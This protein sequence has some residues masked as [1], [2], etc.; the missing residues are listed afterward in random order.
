[1]SQNPEQPVTSQSAAVRPVGAK[2]P[3]DARQRRAAIVAGAVA[4]G[5]FGI[6]WG[7]LSA[8][9][10]LGF[11]VIALGAVLLM[12]FGGADITGG[13]GVVL[14]VVL[15][16]A[17]AVGAVLVVLSV[18]VSRRILRNGGVHRPK[19]VTWLSLLI[20]LVVNTVA[21]RI[22]DPALNITDSDADA[23]PRIAASVV[24]IVVAVGAG[25][26]TWLLMAHAFRA[27]VD[28]AAQGVAGY[29]PAPPAS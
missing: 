3:L 22:A 23:G 5:L 12:L 1:M 6:G 2:V 28:A 11:V 18:A 19:A 21:Q 27:R 15:L 17:F 8:V 10:L 4:G 9:T 29:T 20:V 13:L 25:I 7:V 14:L 24:L 16:V 26:G